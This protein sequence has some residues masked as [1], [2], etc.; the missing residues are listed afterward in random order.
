MI[1][2]TSTNKKI[3][4]ALLSLS[5]AALLVRVAGMLN[6][7]VVSSRFGAGPA[8]D[9]YFVAA[10]IPL[11]LSPLVNDA[12]EASVIPIYT[13]VR[14]EERPER[15]TLFFNTLLNCCLLGMSVLTLLMFLFRTPL[16][17]FS[18]P[19]LDQSRMALALAFVPLLFPCFWL[20]SIMGFLESILNAEGQFG[21]PAYA[22]MLV[23]LS[24][25]AVVLL[26]SSSV[27]ILVLGVGMLVGLF[28][29]AGV[30]LVRLRQAG[31]RYRWAMDLRMPEIRAV[32][33]LA[34]PV[35]LAAFATQA[36]PFFD[37]VVASF[38]VPGSISGL[39]YA[40]KI[41]SV[42]VGILFV[43][44]GRAMLPYLSR[45][46]AEKDMAMFK[47]TLHL[48]LWICGGITLLITLFLLFFAYPVVSLLFQ[49]GAF[50][51]DDTQRTAVA[52]LGFTVGLVPKAFT[53]LLAKAFS[54]LGRTKVLMAGTI[55]CIVLNT[56][57]DVLFAFFWGE[58]GI[59]LATSMVYF[60]T[61]CMMLLVLRRSIGSL[62]LFSPPPVLWNIFG[63]RRQAHMRTHTGQ[64]E[65][66]QAGTAPVMKAEGAE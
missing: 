12:L 2:F 39:N 47:E 25:A 57:F 53:F 24:T 10:S 23:P 51:A 54:A 40:N 22:G 41:I 7:L 9:A 19:A 16:L 28:L 45:Q 32:L 29:Q 30:F 36:L 42:P 21:W 38:L 1:Q 33:A 65:Q 13:R 60:G 20:M 11:L 59:A 8:M 43:S 44:I 18:A 3:L 27:G 48:Y 15:T 66:V 35:L 62:A 6:Q 56:G 55:L 46:S 17:F 61:M 52:L 31:I 5:S 64:A 4:R 58:F 63:L 49:R 37:Q 50:T 14:S 26:F 34:W